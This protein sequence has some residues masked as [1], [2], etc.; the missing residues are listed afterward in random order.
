[1]HMTVPQIKGRHFQVPACGGFVVTSM[2]DDLD[3]W[4]A[5]GKEMI[6]YKDVDE[7]TEQIKHYLSHD[8]ERQAIARAG[9]ERTLRNHTYEKRFRAIFKTMGLER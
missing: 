2:A 3:E 5:P 6:F 4:Y 1:M 9:Y 8:A 7:M